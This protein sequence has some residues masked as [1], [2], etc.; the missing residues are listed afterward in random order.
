MFIKYIF[1]PKL[2]NLFH[3]RVLSALFFFK[4]FRSFE[5]S[6]D[7]QKVDLRLFR[8]ILMDVLSL[9]EGNEIPVLFSL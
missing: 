4:S 7:N 6:Y 5:T 3:F 8:H 2:P 1:S 9:K